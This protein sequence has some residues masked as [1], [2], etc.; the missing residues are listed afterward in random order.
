MADLDLYAIIGVPRDAN[1]KTINHFYRQKAK[2][3]H[4]DNK[5]TGDEAKFKELKLAFDVLFDPDRREKY[6]RTGEIDGDDIDTTDQMVATA[7]AEMLTSVLQ[8]AG[9]IVTQDVVKVMGEKL[10][11]KRNDFFNDRQGMVYKLK[12]ARKL[13][14]RFKGDDISKGVIENFITMTEKRIESLDR[15]FKVH[16]KIEEKWGTYSYNLYVSDPED[17]TPGTPGARGT[18]GLTWRQPFGS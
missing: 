17:G 10:R 2:V 13:Q 3:L 6:D 11:E 9:D 7:I 18:L 1:R 12:R 4:P 15:A 8:G 14:R 5:E 16:K